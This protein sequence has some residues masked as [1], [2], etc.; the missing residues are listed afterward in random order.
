MNQL[1][2]L[3]PIALLVLAAACSSASTAAET[4]PFAVD[5]DPMSAAS[6]AGAGTD[7]AVVSRIV[8]SGV[9]TC[10]VNDQ[11]PGFGENVDGTYEGFDIDFCRAI[12]AALLGD[13]EAVAFVPLSSDVRFTA[14]QS[15]EVDVLIRNT[16]HT[17]SRDGVEGAEFGPTTFYDGQGV[18]V[19]ADSPFQSLD[20]MA[21]ATMCVLSSTTT[22]ANMATINDSRGLEMELLAFEDDDTLQ[23][24]FGNGECDGWTSDK[25]SLAGRRSTYPAGPEAVRILEDTL[26]KE[27]LG[28]AIRQG[29]TRW[30]NIVAWTVYA[31]IQADEYG[32]DSTNLGEFLGTED[33]EIA[34]FLGVGEGAEFDP[35]LGLPVDFVQKVVGGVGSYSEVYDRHVGPDTP[36]G[37]DAGLNRV[38]TD[39]GLLY[40]PP[41]R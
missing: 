15:G 23:A 36:L 35:G 5:L 28:P 34:R 3:L 25:S 1:R 9:V 14:L 12:A 27:P 24:A 19:A 4:N 6:V 33:P 21:G 39:G 41:Y 10:G 22:Q 32:I 17:A 26:S 18:M 30:E 40:A 20:D 13:V 11:N 7:G 38:W 31:M 16:T 8:E 2:S 29:D 37:L